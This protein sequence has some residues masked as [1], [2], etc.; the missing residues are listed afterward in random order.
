MD[1]A[2]ILAEI[3]RTAAE[4]QGRPLGFRR[5]SAET[6]IR[7]G[8]WLGKHWARWND[9]VREAG[10]E[11]NTLRGALEDRFLLERYA[12]LVRELGH[13]PV[14]NE[15][16]MKTHQ[17]ST[18]PNDKTILGRLGAWERAVPQLIDYCLQAGGYDDVV[19]ICRAWQG[20]A[21]ARED[22]KRGRPEKS[23]V[24]GYVYLLRFGRHYK[25]G[26]SNA[27]GRRERELAIQ[28][29]QKGNLIHQIATDDPPG[30]EAYWHRRFEAKRGNG[31]WFNLTAED[32][33]AFRRR[34]SM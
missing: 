27:V 21:P 10:F 9:A 22:V 28:L 4:N 1:K 33:A 7:D 5:F 20:A 11:A 6:G 15:L 24:L 14:R 19:A 26:R 16:R 23:V 32:V 3:R 8:D 34:R 18:F 30:I 31:E 2:F 29:P 12:H 17:D 13:L 25:I